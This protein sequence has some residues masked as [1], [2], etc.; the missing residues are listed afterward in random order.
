MAQRGAETV[1]QLDALSSSR[2]R[3]EEVF[4]RSN[5]SVATVVARVGDEGCGLGQVRTG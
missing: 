1:E 5:L 3:K 2:P 4:E